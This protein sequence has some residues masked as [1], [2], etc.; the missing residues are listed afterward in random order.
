MSQYCSMQVST[1]GKII[2]VYSPSAAFMAP[3]G[4]VKATWQGRSLS[5]GFRFISLC[6]VVTV[7]GIFGDTGLPHS[8]WKRHGICA[9]AL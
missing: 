9:T 6:P 5:V 2:D 8:W 7:W 3:S 1:P 4:A